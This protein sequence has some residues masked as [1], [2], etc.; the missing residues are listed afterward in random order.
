[1]RG[2]ACPPTVL[3]LVE[4]A[5]DNR[6]QLLRGDVVQ[7]GDRALFAFVSPFG[8]DGDVG[9]RGVGH[10]VSLSVLRTVYH[11]VRRV[12]SVVVYSVTFRVR[13]YAR[14]ARVRNGTRQNLWR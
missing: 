6:A 9:R 5:L 1:M 4:V 13:R 8:G 3:A 11:T 2:V 12:S 7:R 14:M 10:V